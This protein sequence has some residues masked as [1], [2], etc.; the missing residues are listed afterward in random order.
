MDLP[1]GLLEEMNKV[2]IDE[3]RERRRAEQ[4]ARRKR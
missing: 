2:L 3:A 1:Y 4:R